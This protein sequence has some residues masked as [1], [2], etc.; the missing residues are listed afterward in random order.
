M[1]KGSIY[2]SPLSSLLL[3]IFPIV[4]RWLVHALVQS[5]DLIL[6]KQAFSSANPSAGRCNHMVAHRS[7]VQ[8]QKEMHLYPQDI[9]LKSHPTSKQ[10]CMSMS[11]V[12]VRVCKEKACLNYTARTTY[13][14]LPRYKLTQGHTSR[15]QRLPEPVMQPLL[16]LLH[17]SHQPPRSGSTHQHWTL[18][19]YAAAPLTAMQLARLLTPPVLQD[20]A[21]SL[22]STSAPKLG[23]T[24]VDLS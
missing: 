10:Q 18:G 3:S 15:C 2:L 11:I 1:Y 12:A 14:N 23:T 19:T 4:H 8:T 13:R 20:P 9:L 6:H 17:L 5:A 22:I 7:Y 21:C 24:Q 16:P